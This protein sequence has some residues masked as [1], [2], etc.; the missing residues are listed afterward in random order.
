VATTGSDEV[1]RALRLTNTTSGPLGSHRDIKKGRRECGV[2]AHRVGET[3][4]RCGTSWWHSGEGGMAPMAHRAA[5]ERRGALR[6][7]EGERGR[8]VRVGAGD[9]KWGTTGR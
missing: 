3:W 6:P 9:C 1:G 5:P 8:L 4:R 7:A 2:A